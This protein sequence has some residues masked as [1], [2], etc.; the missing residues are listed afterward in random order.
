M[1]K[2]EEKSAIRSAE[3]EEFLSRLLDWGR[4]LEKK[5]ST[6]PSSDGFETKK[7]SAVF[8]DVIGAPDVTLEEKTLVDL[9]ESA[10]EREI[11][12]K[13][14]QSILQLAEPLRKAL[15]VRRETL[16]RAEEKLAKLRAGEN[17]E[18]PAAAD[19]GD[20]PKSARN[21]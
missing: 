16:E 8:K 13:R 15:T 17:G 7:A 18:T 21:R 1:F 6:D 4:K 20:E 9:K 5:R 2:D 11:F 14:E 12:E 3:D 19:D 10:E